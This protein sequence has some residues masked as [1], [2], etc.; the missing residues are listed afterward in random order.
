MP[1][2]RQVGRGV[3][4]FLSVYDILGR[5]VAVLVNE[6]LILGTYKFDKLNIFHPFKSV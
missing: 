1:D 3:F 6:Q 4:T 2:G 5:E